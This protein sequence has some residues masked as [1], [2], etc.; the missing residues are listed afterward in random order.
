VGLIK[1]DVE[2]Q[3]HRVLL[4][5]VTIL[6]EDRPV[7]FLE[8]LREADCRALESLR[9]EFHYACG[10]LQ[11]DGISWRDRVEYALDQ[12]DHFLCPAEKI[13]RFNEVVRSTGYRVW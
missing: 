2:S 6:R 4:G 10:L 8:I 13:N 12:N 7:I 9:A 11:P 5:M 1:I 3:E